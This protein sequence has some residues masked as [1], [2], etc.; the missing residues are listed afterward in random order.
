[1]TPGAA[2]HRILLSIGQT[3]TVAA[4]RAVKEAER[5]ALVS[6]KAEDPATYQL[7]VGAFLARK[8]RLSVP[9]PPWFDDPSEDLVG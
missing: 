5:A 1:M 7:V 8:D 4:L 3:E 6:L 2:A 9:M